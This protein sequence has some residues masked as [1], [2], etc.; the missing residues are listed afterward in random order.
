MRKRR[1]DEIAD[2]LSAI[3]DSTRPVR[4]RVN[5]CLSL[6]RRRDLGR[7]TRRVVSDH[8]HALSDIAEAEHNDGALKMIDTAFERLRF[9]KEKKEEALEVRRRFKEAAR[10]IA[11]A[12]PGLP[13]GVAYAG[14]VWRWRIVTDEEKGARV[15]WKME[16]AA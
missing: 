8:L 14:Y 7:P 16:E 11:E 9:Y 4:A 1:D 13:P 3:S 6:I 12:G 5:D 2:L 10:Q 15:Q